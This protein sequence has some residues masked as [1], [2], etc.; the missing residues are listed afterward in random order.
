MDFVIVG[1][2]AIGLVLASKL[3]EHGHNV[4]VLV[5]SKEQCK[6]IQSGGGL[7]FINDVGEEKTLPIG[8]TTNPQNL[9]KKAIWILAVK[10]HHLRDMQLLFDE[11]PEETI[12]LFIQNGIKHIEFARDL[13][14][15]NI[16]MGTI[17]FGAEKVNSNKV[18]HRGIGIFNIANFKGEA[19]NN[20][21]CQ[22]LTAIDL[23]ISFS[24]NYLEMLLRKAIVNCLINTLTTLLGVP[25]GDLIR[26]PSHHRILKEL[27]FEIV[28][29]F[30]EQK[31][32]LPF[33]NIEQICKNTSQNTSSMLAD[34]RHGR[35]MEIDTIV[36][37]VMELAKERGHDLP[38]LKTLY[39][40][41]LALEGMEE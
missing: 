22:R 5:H 29:A 30:P 2:G 37:G 36:G 12:L 33:S 11:L 32:M 38:M 1:G 17:E 19:W 26:L 41:L 16:L 6:A 28:S 9:N 40:L 8:V 31:N 25:N 34:Y 18:I 7:T 39:L 21:E 20:E 10:Y 24:E 15:K 4:E 27:Y 14:Q 23:P 3:F 35:K 13:K